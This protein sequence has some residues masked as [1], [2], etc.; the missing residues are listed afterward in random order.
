L[1]PLYDWLFRFD[2]GAF[3]MSHYGQPV[4]TFTSRLGR[5]IFDRW[6]HTEMAYKVMHMTRRYQSFIIQD[7]AIP[8]RHGVEFLKWSDEKLQIY[9]L[10]LC[11]IDPDTKAPLHRERVEMKEQSTESVTPMSCNMVM[12]TASSPFSLAQPT[13]YILNIGVYGV[14]TAEHWPSPPPHDKPSYHKTWKADNRAIEAKVKSLGGRKWLYAQNFYTETEFW[15]EISE[16]AESKSDIGRTGVYDK[17]EY[18]ALR[19]KYTCLAAASR[20]S[21]IGDEE[22]VYLPSLWD[23][24]KRTEHGYVAG[25]GMLKAMLLAGIGRNHL[26]RKK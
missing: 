20:G 14:P 16:N 7:L 9:P 25:M 18:D 13:D 10:W 3:W 1:I 26:L 17:H 2:R 19:R 12:G 6:H 23:K 22:D 21:V 4:W 11:P 8:R 15:G 5:L 24:V